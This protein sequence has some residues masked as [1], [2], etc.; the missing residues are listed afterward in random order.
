MLNL[1]NRL[2]LGCVLL[3]SLTAGLVIATHGALAAAGQS[4]LAYLILTAAVLVAA[5]TIYFVLRPIGMLAR[6]A[7]RIAQ[8]NVVQMISAGEESG[9]LDQIL[10]KSA[11]FLSVYA[12]GF[13][14]ASISCSGSI[15]RSSLSICP[16]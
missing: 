6:D 8:G 10:T 15:S 5:G 1:S 7:R 14:N 3:T 4:R 16:S 13:S 12:L 2:I 9:N 11:S